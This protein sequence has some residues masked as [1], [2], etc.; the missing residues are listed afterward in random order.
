MTNTIH[1]SSAMPFES[2]CAIAAGC[3]PRADYRT[4][5]EALHAEML[6]ALAAERERCAALCDGIAEACEHSSDGLKRAGA[7]SAAKAC[8][9]LIRA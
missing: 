7:I 6:A 9:K 4:R 2:R 5:L 1:Q 3:L 8:A